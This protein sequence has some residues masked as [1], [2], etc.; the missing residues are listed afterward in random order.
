MSFIILSAHLYAFFNMQH[1]Q[2]EHAI[3]LLMYSHC[4][5]IYSDRRRRM[6]GTEVNRGAASISRVTRKQSYITWM[7][8]EEER[9]ADLQCEWGE[10]KSKRLAVSTWLWPFLAELNAWLYI[11]LD[12]NAIGKNAEL[13]MEAILLVVLQ[14]CVEIIDNKC[15][16]QFTEM[17]NCTWNLDWKWIVMNAAF[18]EQFNL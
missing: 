10:G 15:I 12:W 1:M 8:C 17:C 2:T 7:W 5:P 13:C 9:C 4:L 3:N 14:T 11:E 18:W 6:A 16:F